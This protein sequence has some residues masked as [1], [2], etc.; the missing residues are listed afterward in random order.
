MT[1][2]EQRANL[3]ALLK[4]LLFLAALVSTYAVIFH[5]IKLNVEHEQHSWIT[6]FYWTLVVM[7]TLGFGDV[8]FTSTR[9]CEP[10][11]PVSCWPTA[12]TRST[13]TSP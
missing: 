11:R 9:T 4:Y 7:S 3:R 6:G 10:A 5:V 13:P 1:D 12:R 2:R 8:T